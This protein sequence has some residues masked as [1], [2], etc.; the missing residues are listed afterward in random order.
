MQANGI[1]LALLR[2]AL[3]HSESVPNVADNQVRTEDYEWLRE[4]M[5]S[6]ET[7]AQKIQKLL[8]IVKKEETSEEQKHAAFEELQFL[9]EDLDNASDFTKL[10]GLS[11]TLQLIQQTTSESVRVWALWLLATAVQ[12]HKAVQEAALAIEGCL[13]TVVTLLKSATS[14]LV[15]Q[16]ALYAIIGLVKDN[17]PAQQ[18]FVKLGGV[19]NLVAL[20][21][22]PEPPTRMKSAF[23]LTRLL[24]TTSP[25]I[26]SDDKVVATFM[27][28]RALALLVA[29][30]DD[31]N[32][33]AREKA[34]A[35]LI[36]L[37]DNE[38]VRAQA[39]TLGLAAVARD[40]V[41]AIA[42]DVGA[43]KRT[44]EEAQDAMAVLMGLL[45]KIEPR[46]K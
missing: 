32:D 8:D 34:V 38:K 17:K 9:V 18:E 31:P 25:S 40:R 33:D 1:D 10:E 24:D 19:D 43:G 37:T 23:L 13:S 42:T 4:A 30:V 5:K 6:F 28:L 15:K 16:K 39:E 3:Q 14:P 22:H 44:K 26:A 20:L 27:E 7:D 29:M 46:K 35:L 41:R 21:D 12:N 36:R 2:L 45:T 11:V